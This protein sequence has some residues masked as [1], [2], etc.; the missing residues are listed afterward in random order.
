ML[1]PPNSAPRRANHNV[2]AGKLFPENRAALYHIVQRR[3]I[4]H[5]L[6]LVLSCHNAGFHP[7]GQDAPVTL[8]VI[9][10]RRAQGLVDDL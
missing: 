3:P 8:G 4:S 7:V 1:R 10:Q 9:F 2:E 6:Q 5:I